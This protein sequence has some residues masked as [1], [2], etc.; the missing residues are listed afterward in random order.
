MKPLLAIA[1]IAIAALFAPAAEAKT[2][3]STAAVLAF[4][5][6]SPCPPTGL[7]RGKCPGYIVDHIEPLCA[8]GAD[9][10]DNMQWQTAHEAKLKDRLERRDC[11]DLRK[12]G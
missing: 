5:R 6:A 2:P 11:R 9:R 10:P 3:R 8:R 12:L 4:K 7:R 1:L